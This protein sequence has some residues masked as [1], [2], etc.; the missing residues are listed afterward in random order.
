[1]Q[2]VG[3]VGCGG[4]ISSGVV[5]NMLDLAIALETIRMQRMTY[6]TSPNDGV[7]VLA[8]ENSNGKV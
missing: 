7:P 3:M 8:P 6:K 2:I 4:T 5:W 1:M